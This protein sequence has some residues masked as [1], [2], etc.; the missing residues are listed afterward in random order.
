MTTESAIINE[1]KSDDHL[2][3]P[4]IV[5]TIGS[6]SMGSSAFHVNFLMYDYRND[7]V[8]TPLISN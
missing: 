1:F 6:V 3:F 7:I 2:V 4:I 5:I 8:G